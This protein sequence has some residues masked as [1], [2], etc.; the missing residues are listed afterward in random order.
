MHCFQCVAFAARYSLSSRAAGPLGQLAFCV[1]RTRLLRS[2]TVI[3]QSFTVRICKRL[4]SLSHA[5]QLPAYFAKLLYY[6][7]VVRSSIERFIH[8]CLISNLP[9]L[10]R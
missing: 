6:N 10:F 7:R 9:C 3:C 2:V 4:E 5:L 1:F 8:T